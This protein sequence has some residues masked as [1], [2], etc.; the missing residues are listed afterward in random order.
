MKKIFWIPQL[1][2]VD[3][4]TGKTV[5]NADSNITIMNGVIDNLVNDSPDCPRYKFDIFMPSE[6]F[7]N[8]TYD[9]AINSWKEVGIYSSV[10]KPISAFS[11]RYD[12]D[13]Q[14][15]VNIIEDSEPDYIVNNTP[16]LTRN[17][18]AVLYMLKSKLSVQPKLINFLHF[19]DYPGENKV[20]KEISYFLRQ[21]EGVLCSDLA[22]FQSYTV[23]NKVVTAIDEYFSKLKDVINKNYRLVVWNATYSQAAVDKYTGLQKFQEK[24][25][26]FPNR[27]SATN[28]S[29]HLRFFEAIRNI[30]KTRNDFKV[31]VNNPT[32]Y[33]SYDEISKLCPNLKILN[34][35]NLLNREQY[36]QTLNQADIGVALFVQE[37]HGGVSSKEFQAAGCL[38]V[39]PQTN[40]YAY[41]MPG[42]YQG[43]CKS[44]LSDLESAL[45]FA[46]NVCRTEEGYKLI[47]TGKKLIFERDS[48]EF[49]IKK[50]KEDLESLW[51]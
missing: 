29:N 26:I 17:L 25:I 34:N 43:F 33:M 47:E 46:L 14:E 41:L 48:F 42:N 18:K 3:K 39:F 15:M 28:Y 5:I 2:T 9:K 37:G 11:L 50:V 7:C 51:F 45:N 27:L 35:G 31:I 13:F 38:P 19:L 21:I 40:E 22:V 23:K 8:C 6:E 49:N 24:T 10:H 44:D 32:Q 36:F 1:A 20:P 12:F 4:K 30:S 16:S